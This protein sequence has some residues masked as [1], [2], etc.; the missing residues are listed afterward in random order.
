MEWQHKLE[1]GK[2][3][4]KDHHQIKSTRTVSMCMMALLFMMLCHKVILS[5][6]F[7]SLGLFYLPAAL[8]V[9]DLAVVIVKSLQS[10][11]GWF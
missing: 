8:V 11:C 2:G 4:N 3:K 7:L 9:V 6:Y 5:G 10:V 1:G